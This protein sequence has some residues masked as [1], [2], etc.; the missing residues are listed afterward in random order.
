M[1]TL[2]NISASFIVLV[3]FVSSCKKDDLTS[4]NS[5]N[6]SSSDVARQAL[7][8]NDQQAAY[9]TSFQQ[10]AEQTVMM[11]INHIAA[12][13][14]FPDYSITIKFDGTIIFEGRR[15]VAFIGTKE[16][17]LAGDKFMNVKQ[18]FDHSGFNS[19]ED[20]LSLLA[21]A[22]MV[23]TTWCAS[24][25]QLPRTLIDYYQGYPEGL[26]SLREKAENILN[27]VEFVSGGSKPIKATVFN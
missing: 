10:V 2:K 8:N 7:Q 24:S 12:R 6:S 4:T 23:A 11:R 22:P 19:I 15:N 14:Q 25:V 27:L 9:G 16:W 5:G 13:S 26:I 3:L 1:K 17:K 21:D 20:R 18:L